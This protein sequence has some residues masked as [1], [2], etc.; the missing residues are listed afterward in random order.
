MVDSIGSGN[1]AFNDIQ[2]LRQ[3]FQASSTN[4]TNG[5]LLTDLKNLQIQV[6]GPNGQGKDTFLDTLVNN[7][8]SIDKDGN[9]TISKQEMQGF[10]HNQGSIKGMHHHGGHKGKKGAAS[11]IDPT[12]DDDQD[13]DPTSTLFGTNSSSSTNPLSTL[14]GSNSGSSTNPIS[15]L[16]NLASGSTSNSST[17]SNNPNNLLSALFKQAA[18][19]YNM[20][21]N[22]NLINS[23]LGI[24]G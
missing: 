13:T 16:L 5:V 19:M 9:G 23:T 8:S 6:E 3:M 4:G 7:F 2:N 18:T 11:T 20:Q 1:Q 10:V 12:S 14:F 17:N 21:N 22:P 15:T 24:T